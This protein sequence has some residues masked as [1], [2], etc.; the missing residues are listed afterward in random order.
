M[1]LTLTVIEFDG[2]Y[3]QGIGHK[4]LPVVYAE[5]RILHGAKAALKR[6]SK[7]NT[8]Q[9]GRQLAKFTHSCSIVVFNHIL[10]QLEVTAIISTFS[11]MPFLICPCPALIS[12]NCMI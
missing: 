10:S 3:L 12:S 5:S 11:S 4:P 2:R 9:I 8:K 6:L 1:R 7:E